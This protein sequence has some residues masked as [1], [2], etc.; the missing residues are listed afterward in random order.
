MHDAA[1]RMADAIRSYGNGA[2]AIAAL[3]SLHP[4]SKKRS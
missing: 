3:E 2:R 4:D 1:R